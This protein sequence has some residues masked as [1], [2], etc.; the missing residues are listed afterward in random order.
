[1]SYVGTGDDIDPETGAVEISR[2]N[3]TP[4]TSVIGFTPVH[5]WSKAMIK[6]GL[7][8]EVTVKEAMETCEV[9]RQGGKA[10]A[11]T[12]STSSPGIKPNNKVD[13]IA[14]SS[15]HH[16]TVPEIV[17]SEEEK[18]LREKVQRLKGEVKDARIE[19]KKA[20]AE[21]ADERI[22]MLGPFLSNPFRDVEGSASQQAI[23]MTIAVRKQ[24]TKM[25]NL[26]PRKKVVGPSDMLETNNTFFNQDIEAL[27]EG[28]PGSEYCTQYVY[29]ANRS[30]S[31]GAAARLAQEAQARQQKREEERK[32][33]QAAEAKAKAAKNKQQE[34]KRKRRDDE[35]DARKRQ[36]MEEEEGKKHQRAEE[37]MTRL[38]LQV[39]DR[40]AKEVRQARERAIIA[41][42]RYLTKEFVRRRKAA[43]VVAGEVATESKPQ[44]IESTKLSVLPKNSKT[45]DDDILRI[46]DY[47]ATFG[48]FFVERGFIDEVP[49][50]DSLQDAVNAIRGDVSSKITKNE[51]IEF[52]TRFAVFLCKPL[53]AG[54]TRMLIASL[55]QLTPQLQKEYGAAYFNEVNSTKLN[56]EGK[57]KG[58]SDMML[59]VDE[60]SWLEVAR[61]AFLADAVG[62][63]GKERHEIAHILR[64]YRSVGHPNSKEA[65]RMR[66]VEDFPIALLRQYLDEQRLKELKQGPQEAASNHCVRMN[67]P[68]A[69]SCDST[70][71]TF[72]LHNA[73][74][75]SVRNDTKLLK[76]CISQSLE[77]LR[78]SQEKPE[79]SEGI[80]RDLTGALQSLSTNPDDDLQSLAVCLRILDEYTGEIYS[81]EKFEQVLQRD[82]LA[83]QRQKE[84]K[85]ALR[86]QRREIMGQLETLSLSTHQYKD[87]GRARENYMAEALRLKE[88]MK[89]QQARE[90]G[91]EDDDDDDDDEEE[92]EEAMKAAKAESG[93]EE[94]S[95]AEATIEHDVATNQS[96]GAMPKDL[97]T[98]NKE[99]DN[100]RT[101]SQKVEAEASGPQKIGKQSQYDDFCGDIPTAP[102][103]I[104]RCLAVLRNLSQ[105]G[106]A[107]PFIYP[108]DPQ[109]NPGYYDA[110]IRPMCMRE[111]GERLKSAAKEYAGKQGPDA[112]A[113]VEQTVAD[114]A[115]NV[116]LIAKNT[117]TYGNAGPTI[118]CAGAEMLRIF[119]RLFLDWVIAPKDH[120][121]ALDRLDDEQC[122]EPH[123]S[124]IESTVLLCDGCEGNWNIARLDPPLLQIPEGDWYCPRCVG[125]RCWSDL[126]PRISKKF[127]KSISSTPSTSSTTVQLDGIVESSAFSFKEGDKPTIF[128]TVK[129]QDGSTEKWSIDEVESALKES[130]V[131]VEPISC[132]EAVSESR[133]YG[134]GVNDRRRDDLV[135]AILNPFVSDAAS[136]IYLSSSVF[137]DS[138]TTS[139]TIMVLDPQE[140]TASE[141]IRMLALLIM[142]SSASDLMQNVATEMENEAA[143]KMAKQ[144][145]EVNKVSQISDVLEPP[146]HDAVPTPIEE[147]VETTKED[148]PVEAIVEE[149]TSMEIDS[150]SKDNEGATMVEAEAVVVD[151]SA[152]EVVEGMEVE[153]VASEGVP[154][155][156]TKPEPSEE[157]QRKAKRSASLVEKSKRQKAREDSISAFCI[158]SQ[159]RPTVA[160][161]EQDAV[162][163]V[164]ESTL[165]AKDSG[166]NFASSRCRGKVCDFCGLSD[167]ALGTNLVRVPDDKEWLELVKF[168]T[169]PRRVHL[170]AEVGDSALAGSDHSTRSSSTK[171]MT[172]KIRVGDALVA[173][174]EDPELFDQI[175]DNEILEFL[176]RN[177]DGFQDELLFR[178]KSELP[179]VT[180]SMSA[181]ECCAIAA[182]NA[183][184]LDIV[185]KYK[186]E[187]A[188]TLERDAGM[189]CGRTLKIGN[190]G[191]GRSYWIFHSDPNSLFVL[192]EADNLSSDQQKWL[193]FSDPESIA[194]II[195]GLGKGP[196]VNELKRVFPDA[197]KLVREGTW[198]S[199]VLARKFRSSLR[200]LTAKPKLK[201]DDDSSSVDTEGAIDEDQLFHEGEHVFVES[202]C[203]NILWDA[204]VM[205]MS[206]YGADNKSVAYRVRYAGWSSRFDDWVSSERVVEPSHH[207]HEVQDEML[208]DI[209]EARNDL[210]WPLNQMEASKYL[211]SRDRVRSTE[212]L[213]DFA[214]IAR[215]EKSASVTKKTFAT[216]KAALLLIE[217]ALPIGCVDN[218]FN[219]R[220]NSS[221]ARQWREVVKNARGP[222]ELMRCVILLEDIVSSEWI[223]PHVATLRDCLPNRL[224]ALEEASSSSVAMRITLLDKGVMYGS[225]DKK[226][227]RDK[228]S[229]RK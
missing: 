83:E 31:T 56:D 125:G 120:L 212:P 220:W 60:M 151:A 164:V 47:V 86:S 2:L 73:K 36:K 226:R 200:S 70:H 53:A 149:A 162:S 88:E 168:S 154:V 115:R 97:T 71:W 175:P 153:A 137:R 215:V 109:G 138:I 21:L 126:D 210:P 211:H 40:L 33:K 214:R 180:G 163:Q 63:L 93:V 16:E 227:Y 152:V 176:P 209:A 96:S 54:I 135:P 150:P 28:L 132:L 45:Y 190:D 26:G 155:P 193:R 118:V 205:G 121:V 17:Y 174:E 206:R 104:R 72:H 100:S 204:E 171:L 99:S 140:M 196:T 18:D 216:C 4:V 158:K 224:R 81:K 116:R 105:S 186:E 228:K 89:R 77:S 85:S 178:H 130:G 44:Q 55:I 102:E 75:A 110:L 106:P 161:F 181:H 194:S 123:P 58:I 219:G 197:A 35:R 25:G 229:S 82:I 139:G 62:E 213:S 147:T 143:E 221:R 173:D 90:A 129:F 111:V 41:L 52:F 91:E 38:N 165:S 101:S 218:T 61:I 183:R 46:W 187:Q 169:K 208:I 217:A 59:P 32:K 92:E 122:V 136:P 3:G 184:K 195:V 182:H 192:E 8:D 144:L 198:S 156:E 222:W 10:D 203:G 146:E 29:L 50:L 188:V 177:P 108:V 202:K 43:E 64:G 95:V 20:A 23:W 170:I 13:G 179:V 49:S 157:D 142:K 57:A 15:N 159:L 39:D 9:A 74:S 12:K 14:D 134:M 42:S 37:R 34:A 87:L 94:E 22:K 185:Q 19:S 48:S 160:S 117:Q 51:G 66:K 112:S 113:L 131:F 30:S 79:N 145:E 223:D 5:A 201:M 199:L 124:D 80:I 172:L 189:K 207:N 128:Y 148:E 65:I 127:K 114:F 7:V 191:C 225:V 141:W 69:P 78:S 76:H 6:L 133:G 119:E 107:E 24:K 84:S 103:L 11:T 166:L 98:D 68:C 1:M 167:T 67:L 27:I